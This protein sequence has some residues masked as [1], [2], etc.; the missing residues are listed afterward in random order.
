MIADQLKK[1]VLQA[2]IQGKLT[3]QLPGDGDARDL[4]KEIRA[5]KDCLIREGMIKQDKPLPEVTEDETP[6]DIPDNWCWVRLG[7]IVQVKGGKRIPVGKSLTKADTGYKY[8][9]VADMH[10]GTVQDTDIH[11]VPNDVYPLI[12]N[13]TISSKDVYITCAGTIG[14]VGTIPKEFDSAN[15]TENADKLV[16]DKLDKNWLVF[17]LESPFVQSQIIACTTQVG[18]PKLAIKRIENLIIPLS[19]L[20]EQVRIVNLICSFYSK[21]EELHRDE[22]KLDA[23]QRSFPKKLKDSILQY[24]IQGKLTEQLPEDGDARTLLVAIKAEKDRLIKAGELRQEKPLPEITEDEIPFDIP[25]YWCWC[26]FG[27]IVNFHIGKTPP[28]G[29]QEYWGEGY[30]WVSI[31]DINDGNITWKTKESVTQKA[32]NS[33]FKGHFSPKGSL[34]MSFKLSIGKTS[35]L[36]VD[37]FHNEAIITIDPIIGSEIMKQYFLK[38]LNFV[39]NNGETKGA[40]KGRTLNSMSISEMLIPLPPLV[41]QQ[42]IVDRLN[43][44][45]P[46]CDALE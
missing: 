18:Q 43:E 35:F 22:T 3:D 10:N 40:I 32:F 23:L 46:L 25:A 19:T 45:L 17:V 16:F 5:G 38:I 33:V 28:R 36:G 21:I 6:F 44:L 20:N 29:Q 8:I 12:K 9:R 24:A 34:I 41:E 15:L 4:L 2:A 37:A 26:R 27:D 39:S 42:R 1:A 30:P 7:E 13:Y 31:A 11:Y 14:R